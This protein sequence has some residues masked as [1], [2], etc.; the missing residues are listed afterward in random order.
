VSLAGSHRDL[1]SCGGRE[2]ADETQDKEFESLKIERNSFLKK[3]RC[4]R[5]GFKLCGHVSSLWPSVMRH[6]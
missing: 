6:F 3:E 5:T 2:S 4:K 1:C